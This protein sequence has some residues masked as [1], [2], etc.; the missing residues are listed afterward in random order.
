MHT[1]GSPISGVV[2][3]RLLEV[4]GERLGDEPVIALQGPRTVGKS[5]LLGELAGSC[6]IEV[7]DLDEPAT[8]GAVL[9]DPGAFVDGPSPV[10]IDEYQHV[11]AVLEAIKSF[12]HLSRRSSLASS[13]R[14]LRS[15]R[16]W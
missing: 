16:R 4:A 5:T 2:T 13:C 8:R 15:G 10:C 7:V 3:R 11:P 12:S 14:R 9:A 6:G 1:N